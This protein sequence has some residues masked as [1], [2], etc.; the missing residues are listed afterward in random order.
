MT[1][2]LLNDREWQ[3]RHDFLQSTLRWL[4]RAHVSHLRRILLRNCFT[5][6]TS[7]KDF[8]SFRLRRGMVGTPMSHNTIGHL[9]RVT[10]WGESHGPSIG[11]VIDGCPPGI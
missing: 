3:K 6:N 8:A 5:P 9:F 10:T 1:D 11:C 2:V 4:Q 7:A